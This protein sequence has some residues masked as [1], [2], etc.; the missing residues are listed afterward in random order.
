MPPRRLFRSLLRQHPRATRAHWRSLKAKYGPFD[1][2]TRA[3]AEAVTAMWWS[4]AQATMELGELEG[5]RRN[6]RGRRPSVQAVERL[7]KRQGVAFQS[8]D[9]ALRRLEELAGS[10]KAPTIAEVIR[11]QQGGART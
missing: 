4:F 10:R 1:G 5:K 7:R 6:G 8:Y 11:Q 2:P 3:Y 9:A